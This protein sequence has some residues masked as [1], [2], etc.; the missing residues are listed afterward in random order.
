MDKHNND[1]SNFSKIPKG[2]QYENQKNHIHFQGKNVL[3]NES[4]TTTK[5]DDTLYINDK[6]REKMS[7]DI[8]FKNLITYDDGLSY[9]DMNF[10]LV[11]WKDKY[12]TWKDN[13]IVSPIL[14]ILKKDIFH[15]KLLQQ[16]LKVF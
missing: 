3:L 10:K 8:N 13:E 2:I 14:S 5:G 4:T 6:V 9:Y 11:L 7:N 12:F 16:L 1:K 15:A